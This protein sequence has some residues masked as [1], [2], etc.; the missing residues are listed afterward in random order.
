METALN[1]VTSLDSQFQ[2]YF[3]YF[4]NTKYCICS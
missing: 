4:Q 3:V 1:S 2:M